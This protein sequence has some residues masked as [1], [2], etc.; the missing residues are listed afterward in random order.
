MAGYPIPLPALPTARRG[1]YWRVRITVAD[2]SGTRLDLTALGAADQWTAQARV[3]SV[4]SSVAA[5]MILD[6]TDLATGQL[7]VSLNAQQLR[8]MTNS[9]YEFDVETAD[10]GGAPLTVFSG[11]FTVVG[12]LTQP[13]TGTPDSTVLGTVI[14]DVTVTTPDLTA[15]S[16]T[17]NLTGPPGPK[18]DTGMTGGGTVTSVTAGDSTITVGGTSA[19]PTIAVTSGTF[20]TPADQTTA[21]AAKAD[22]VGGLV[23]SSQLPS[24][25]LGTVQ[26]V[27]SQAAMLALTTTQ[28]QPGDLA[29]R[30]DG[31]GTFILT[32]TDPSV[33]ANWQLL[34]APADLVSSVNGHTGTVVLAKADVGLG[35][36]DNTADS[37]KAVLSATKLATARTINGVSFDGTANITISAGTSDAGSLTG[38]QTLA[39]IPVGGS[40][41][42][43]STDGGTTWKTLD[44]TTITSRPSARTD[45]RMI[46]ETTGTT[47]PSFA[48]TGDLLFKIGT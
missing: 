34:N 39:T 3:S 29:V 14:Q 26:V 41:H 23:P 15:G 7:I 12:D 18:G 22:L 10:S 48:I 47:M 32:A 24:I 4:A 19:D 45:I 27:A 20:V 5:D 16:Y 2:T 40:F 35:S 13:P 30:T 38:T 28:V 44:G 21:L 1:D 37:A 31:A 42:I 46:C 36:V 25:A 33:L 11:A 8:S 9:A 17:V 6:T 43:N